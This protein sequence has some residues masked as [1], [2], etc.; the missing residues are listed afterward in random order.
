MNSD[1]PLVF[2]DEPQERGI[3]DLSADPFR[4]VAGRAAVQS[5]YGAFM[6]AG[7]QP[8]RVGQAELEV[9]GIGNQDGDRHLGGSLVTGSCICV[10]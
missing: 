9:I 7:G 8:D 4:L 1:Q 6:Q 10:A 5:L 3:A 2:Q